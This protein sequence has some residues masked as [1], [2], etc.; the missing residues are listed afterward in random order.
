MIL[1]AVMAVIIMVFCFGQNSAQAQ[2]SRIYFAGYMGLNTYGDLGFSESSA[3]V[4]GDFE[5][6]N[7]TSFA[8]ALGVRLTRQLRAEA[9]I[10]YRKAEI[11][12]VDI[13]GAGSFR[14]GGDVSS[15]FY[16]LNLYYDF[17]LEWQNLQPFIGVGVGFA[18]HEGQIQDIAGFGPAATDD[19][20]SLAWAL[21]GGL[22]YRMNDDVALTGNYR[23]LGVPD[24][25]VD[26]YDVDYSSH[27]IR[28]G[29][30]Y[31]LPVSQ[32]LAR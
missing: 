32:F 17:D 21:G 12:S 5:M 10:S 2:S 28:F 9:E 20:M 22:K 7:A 15:L 31:D 4:S 25:Q 6:D 11:A 19:S 13:A 1:T 14:A 29:L 18:S 3:N 26:S 16:L 24:F 30:E 8:G 23:F 27:E